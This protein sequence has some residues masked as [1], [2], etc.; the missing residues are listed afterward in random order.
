[1]AQVCKPLSGA[2]PYARTDG[3]THMARALVIMW[4]NVAS[5]C[6]E[7]DVKKVVKSRGLLHL[8]IME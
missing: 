8:F 1:M 5:N 7:D 6:C 4:V 3:H 2:D